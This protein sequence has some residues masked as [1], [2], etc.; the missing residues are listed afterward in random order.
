MAKPHI[1]PIAKI[2]LLAGQPANKVSVDYDYLKKI[3][4][5]DLAWLAQFTDEYYGGAKPKLQ[6]EE[7]KKEANHSRYARSMDALNSDT[8]SASH[9]PE[10]VDPNIK[11]EE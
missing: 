9:H 1:K 5:S 3:S 11:H 10:L 7:L 6:T 2:M 4:P 8:H